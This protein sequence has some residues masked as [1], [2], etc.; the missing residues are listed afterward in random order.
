MYPGAWNTLLGFMRCRKY[1]DGERVWEI[2]TR[3][4]STVTTQL[5]DKH[6]GTEG[7]WCLGP[8]ISS[9][10]VNPDLLLSDLSFSII[11]GGSWT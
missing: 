5:C 8:A 6:R 3:P 10:C 2:S 7:T 9:S 4:E 11:N 1:R